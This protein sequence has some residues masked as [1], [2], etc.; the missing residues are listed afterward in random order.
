MSIVIALV[1]VV[2]VAVAF[3]GSTL[4]MRR[5]VRERAATLGPDEPTL[6]RRDGVPV[7]VYANGDLPGG[8]KASRTNHADATLLVSAKRAL[9]VTHHGRIVEAGGR[10]AL[11]ARTTGPRRLVIEGKDPSQRVDVRVEAVVDDVAAWVS[12]LAP[13]AAGG[14]PPQGGR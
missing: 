14:V 7:A 11:R 2:S 5:R 10:V 8:L 3:Q 13:F 6:L 12:A 1:A 9:V 4:W